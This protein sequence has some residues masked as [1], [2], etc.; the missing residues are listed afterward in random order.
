VI[1]PLARLGYAS[2]AFIYATMGLLAAAA[3]LNRGG[4]VT[5]TRGALPV[6]LAHPFGNAVLVVLAIGLCGYCLW[7]V[8]DAFFDPDRRGTSFKGLAFRIGGVIRALIYGGVGVEAFRLAKGLRASG[9][10]DASIKSWTARIMDLPL[11]PWLIAIAGAI[12]AAY[13]VS[14]IVAAIK[15][16]EDEKKD[17][18]SVDTPTRA[19]LCRIARFGVAARALIIVVLG[20]FLVRA[21]LRHDPSEAE[22]VRG[23]LLELVGAVHGRWLLALMAAGLIAYGLDQALHARY[24]RIR[25]PL[26]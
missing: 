8:L 24:R 26:P 23:S 18:S 19:I 20:I 16:D 25:S 9:G 5:D 10:G 14:E 7:R 12:I 13:G 1:T 11:G 21:A 17:M 2:K 3:A 6:I 22:G 15:D 4:R